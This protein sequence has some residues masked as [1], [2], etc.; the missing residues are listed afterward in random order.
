[1][2]NL[3]LAGLLPFS[4]EVVFDEIIRRIVNNH[5][6][7]FFSENMYY[8]ILSEHFLQGYEYDLESLEPVRC[9]D[10][11]ENIRRSSDWSNFR[12]VYYE[13]QGRPCHHPWEELFEKNWIDYFKTWVLPNHDVSLVIDWI[14]SV[15][16]FSKNRTRSQIAELLGCT[17]IGQNM[18]KEECPD[19]TITSIAYTQINNDYSTHCRNEQQVNVENEHCHNEQ[20]T[21]VNVGKPVE[22]NQGKTDLDSEKNND[23]QQ[24]KKKNGRPKKIYQSFR[25]LLHVEDN[26]ELWE[27]IHKKLQELFDECRGDNERARIIWIV[28]K[29]RKEPQ[30]HLPSAPEL[31]KAYEDAS[32]P[33]IN[34]STFKQNKLGSIKDGEFE[35]KIKRL[36]QGMK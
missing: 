12:N 32:L 22:D 29:V 34:I 16:L 19:K 18:H 8:K 27:N 35:D 25:K 31:A 26:D 14:L 9:W 11:E 5:F 30:G 6:K 36:F 21:S 2:G 28:C 7:V 24:R 3:E 13:L 17:A 33:A 10:S 15:P 1:M 4:N 23:T 20:Y